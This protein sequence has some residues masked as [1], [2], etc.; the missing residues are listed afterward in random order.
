MIKKLWVKWDGMDVEC[1]C[2]DHHKKC[3]H[4]PGEEPKCKEYI[5]KFVE[6]DRTEE[7]A[8]KQIKDFGDALK[9]FER[10]V[11]NK[12]KQLNKFKVR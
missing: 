6:I 4:K 9:E 10:E 7:E 2:E 11:Q 8:K 12:V 5:T 3:V 1:V